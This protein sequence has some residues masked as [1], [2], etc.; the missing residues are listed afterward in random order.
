MFPILAVLAILIRGASARTSGRGGDGAPAAGAAPARGSDRLVREPRPGRR[1]LPPAA[2]LHARDLVQDAARDPDD[3][4]LPAPHQRGR[5]A[6]ALPPPLPGDPVLHVPAEHGPRDHAGRDDLHGDQPA[7]R[8]RAGP[9]AL[10]RLR[11]PRDRRLP[12]LPR[13]RDL[14]VH[15]ALQASGRPG[16][17]QLPRGPRARLPDPLGALLH[18]DPHR[19]LRVDSPGARRGRLPRRREPPADARPDLHSRGHARNRRGHDVLVHGLLG[20]DSSIPWRSSSAGT[21]RS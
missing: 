2:V 4:R 3:A 10:P 7:G 6:R 13:A 15:P 19:L 5:H 11:R 8:V 20:Q 17:A 9:A 16:P 12:D 1:A 21:A 18:V 14:A